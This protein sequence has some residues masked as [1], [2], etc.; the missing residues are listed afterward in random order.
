VRDVL[1][2]V[3]VVEVAQWWFAPSAA[4]LLAEWG[5]EVVKI[6]H[7]VHGDPIRGLVTGGLSRSDGINFMA[8]QANHGKR[9]IGLDIKA[10]EGRAILNRLIGQADVFITSFLPQLRSR[11]GLELEDVREVNPRIIYARA[12]GAGAQGDERDQAGFDATSFWARGGVAHHLT[13]PGATASLSP[14]P[15]FGDGI[16]GLSL[17]GAIAA[18]LYGRE[19]HGE[20]SVID[21]SLLGTAL[22]VMSP[23]VVAAAATPGGMPTGTRE[24]APNPLTNCYRTSDGRWIWFVMLQADRH[25]P[26]F[27]THI[28]R[29]DLAA[30]ERFSSA[31]ARAAN[32]AACM[33]ELDDTFARHTLAQWQDKLAGL[34]GAWAVAQSATDLLEDPQVLANGYLAEV[35]YDTRTHSLVTGPAQFDG[36]PP[37]LTRAPAVG[38]HTDEIL[39]ELG[40]GWDEIVKLKL[41]GIVN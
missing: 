24:S 34:S 2:G 35:G 26:E 27:C 41:D 19:R 9:S 6:E 14:R 18:A 31:Q 15:S 4:T 33:A 36:Q 7:P 28:G 22:W 20:P 30:D 38:E 29:P 37:S 10:P 11:L 12:H 39:L 32:L 21:V 25:W 3:R 5:A 40:T 23:D 17:A 13:P 8:E 16:S 1:R